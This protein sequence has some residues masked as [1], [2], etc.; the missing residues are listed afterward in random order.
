RAADRERRAERGLAELVRPDGDAAEQHAVQYHAVDGAQR[1]RAA[2]LA[3][4]IGILAAPY[5]ERVHEDLGRL[6]P[7]AGM[8]HHPLVEERRV[9][10]IRRRR[11]DVVDLVVGAAQQRALRA[12][13]AVAVAAARYVHRRP[14]THDEVAGRQERYG[15]AAR[16]LLGHRALDSIDVAA[17][18]EER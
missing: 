10:E 18:V 12:P 5:P 8:H 14:G 4:D 7:P 9:G 11:A 16:G 1:E 13:R 3:V 15:A 2:R 6:R 17:R